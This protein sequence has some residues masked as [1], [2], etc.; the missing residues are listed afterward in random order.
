LLEKLGLPVNKEMK[1][2]ELVFHARKF[3]RCDNA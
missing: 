1:Y 2:E 3:L